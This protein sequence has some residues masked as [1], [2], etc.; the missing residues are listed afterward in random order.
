MFV[1]TDPN[2]KVKIVIDTNVLVFSLYGLKHIIPYLLTGNLILIWNQYI[3][4]EIKEILERLE[5]STFEKAQITRGIAEKILERIVQKGIKVE[6][7]PNHF[8]AITLDRDDDPFL[9][10]AVQGNAQF[11]ITEDPHI[12]ILRQYQNIPIGKPAEFFIWVNEKHPMKD[13]YKLDI[14]FL[15]TDLA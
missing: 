13:K 11:I 12:L 15:S 6:E 8:P 1:E 2:V 9:W 4:E 5:K 10:A 7:M 14:E 3:I